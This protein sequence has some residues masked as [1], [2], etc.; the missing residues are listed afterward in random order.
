MLLII[1]IHCHFYVCEAEQS[2]MTWYNLRQ[3]IVDE[4][5]KLSKMGLSMEYF[6]VS[7]WRVP[8]TNVKICL[9]GGRLGKHHQIEAFQVFSSN[10]LIS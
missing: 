3:G 8:T 9:L 5:I 4:F 2:M 7:F 1:L 10:F 6:V